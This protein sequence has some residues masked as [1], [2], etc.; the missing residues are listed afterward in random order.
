MIEFVIAEVSVAG[1]LL[2]ISPIPGRTRHYGADWPRLRD[3]RPGLV[4]TM[5][6]LSELARVGAGSLP[7]DLTNAGILW[8][9]VPVANFGVPSDAEAAVWPA[10]QAQALGLL[11]SGG[12][13]LVHCFGGCGRSGMAALRLMVAAGGEPECALHRLRAARACA[14]ET[15]AQ[16]LWAVA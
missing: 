12:R 10:V 6:P 9:H 8:A 7:G 11:R 1:G 14:V 5:T 2:G 13:V 4:I 16:R 3:W 15:E